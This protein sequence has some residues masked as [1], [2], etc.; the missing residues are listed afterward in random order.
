[1]VA[2]RTTAVAK[3]ETV[4]FEEVPNEKTLYELFTL[5]AGI[6]FIVRMFRYFS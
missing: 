2:R 6:P 4:I 3:A 1:V 5:S